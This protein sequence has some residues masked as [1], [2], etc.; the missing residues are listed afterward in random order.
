MLK[1]RGLKKNYKKFT[2]LNGIDLDVHEGEIFGF[3]GPNGAGK[4][5]TMRIL[6]GLLNPTD[7]E[8]M[9]DGIDALA[10]I[11]QTKKLIGYMP[12]FFGVYDNLKVTEYLDFYA[13]VYG[14]KG[15]EKAKMIEDLLELVDLSD[16]KEFFV[17]DLSRGMKQ[18]L[19][20]AR[21]LVHNPK[22]LVLDEPLSGMDPRARAEMKKVLVTLKDMG[23]TV[24]VSSHILSELSEICTSIGIINKGNILLNGTVEEV[25]NKV[26]NSQT[27]EICVKDDVERAK[28]LIKELEYVDSIDTLDNKLV[29]AIKGSDD[30]IISMTKKLV[31]KDIP[32]ITIT[33]KTQNLEDLFLE[34]TKSDVN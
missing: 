9:V 13:S 22:L 29:I 14:I 12:D 19:C 4:T 28:M 21:C 23:K 25:M 32:V 33:R 15:E 24:I 2:A 18:K 10:N 20:I 5:T 26:Y 27:V 7:G 6:C 16:K 1:I 31:N 8:V 3:I 11:Q 34:V 17:D 30:E